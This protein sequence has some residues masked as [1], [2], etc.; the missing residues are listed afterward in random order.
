VRADEIAPRSSVANDDVYVDL[1]RHGDRAVERSTR[2]VALDQLVC[3][4]AVD[5]L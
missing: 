1:G 3:L 5:S 4:L 2:L